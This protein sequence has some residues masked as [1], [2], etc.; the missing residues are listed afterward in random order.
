MS[1]IIFL[2]P[3][4]LRWVP[5]GI[6]I[7]RP[8]R[9]HHLNLYMYIAIYSNQG[10]LLMFTAKINIDKELV[11]LVGSC[12]VV[13]VECCSSYSTAIYVSIDRFGILSYR[14]ISK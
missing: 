8:V 14:A 10:G 5:F 6:G 4:F 13:A 1:D 3:L 9:H 11:V 7:G 12:C 2:I